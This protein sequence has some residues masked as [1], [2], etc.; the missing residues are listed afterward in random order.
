[1]NCSHSRSILIVEDELIVARDLQRS[2]REMGY[3][4]FAIAAT[5]EEAIAC[6]AERRPDIVLMDIRI[7]GRPDGIETAA[8]L[9][10]LHGL[11][12]IYLTAHADDAMLERAKSTTPHGYMLK[13]IRLP[14]LRSLLEITSYQLDL[15]DA[16]A[17]SVALESENRALIEAGRL[18]DTSRLDAE[19]ALSASDDKFQAVVGGIQDYAIF[20]LDADGRVA[21]WNAGAERM[22][23]YRAEE[24]IGRHFSVLYPTHD[25]ADGKPARE[26][27]I[28]AAAGRLEDEGWRSRKDGSQFIANV[29]IT[30]LRDRSGALQG[31]IKVTRDITERKQAENA[32]KRSLERF[33]IAAAAAPMGFWDFDMATATLT[34]DAGMF[35][36]YGVAQSTAEN[37]LAQWTRSLHPDDRARCTAEWADAIGGT[38]DYDTTFRVIQ[39]DGGIRHLKAAAHVSLNAQTQTGRMTGVAF[40]VTAICE[41]RNRLASLAS[42][43]AGLLSALHQHALVSVADRSGRIIDV[44]DAFCATSG[45]SREELLGQDHR[46]LNSGT[47]GP[48]FWKAA[49]R[50]IS[51][52]TTWRGQ[53]CNR[54][55]NGSLYWVDGVIVPV[56]DEDGHV[57][58]YIFL[59]TD[60]TAAKLTEQKL[61]A[62]EAFL[63]RVGAVA[64]IGGWEFDLATQ[65]VTWSTE[66]YRIHD[67]QPGVMQP[68]VEGVFG[69]YAPEA[70]PVLKQAID[71]AITD[72]TAYDLELR[73]VTA[74]GRAIWVRAVGAAEMQAGKTVRLVGALQ[75]ITARRYIEAQ[76]A[77]SNERFKIAA[78]SGAIGI[79]E[80]DSANNTLLW[81]DQMYRIYGATRSAGFEPYACWADRLH[82]E[83]KQRCHEEIESAVRE[84]TGFNTEFRIVLST[85]EIRHVKACSH[86]TRAA[87]GAGLRVI[88]VNI[89]VTD[90]R[91]TEHRL[92]ETSSLLRTVL[93]SA[94]DVSIIATDPSLTIKVFNAG[95][96]RLLGYASDELV[97]RATPLLIHDPG[98]LRDC[99]AE[100]SAELGRPIEGADVFV[101]PSMHGRSRVWR[102]LRKDGGQVP[103]SLVITPMKTYEGELLGYV[104]VAQDVTHQK[105]YEES[106]R[107]ATQEAERANTAKSLFLANMSH[108]IR[109]PMNAVIGLTYLLGRTE[110]NP[111]QGALL[112]QISGA[113]KSLLSVITDVLDLSKIEA[114]ELVI[115]RVAFDPPR[116]LA[117]L[118]DTMRVHADA[119]GIVLQMDLGADLPLA[120]EGDATRL[121]Q[122]LTNLLSNAIKFTERGAVT[123][124]VR[125][126]TGTAAAVTLCFTVRD[127][128]IGIA[129]EAQARL[130]TPF[131][132]ADESITRR[133]GGTG[134]GLSII[135]NLAKLMGGTVD[136]TS[137]VG[138]GS[139]FRVVLDFARAEPKSLALEQ[140]A[141]LIRAERPLA[142]VRV[143]IVDDYDLNLVV[144]KRI[145]EQEGAQVCSA[146]NG[147]EAC[148]QLQAR[149]HSF[150]VVLMDVQ[151]PIMDGYEATRRIRVELGLV[152]LP[153][154][155][156]TAGA[157]SSERQRA[158]AVGMDGFIIKPFDAPTLIAN[159]LHH[160]RSGRTPGA[161]P[162]EAQ[163]EPPAEAADPWLEIDG[164]DTDDARGRWCDDWDL[165]RSML[166]RCLDEFSDIAVPA[167]ISDS[168]ALA[169]QESRLH[170]LRGGAC[171]LGARTVQVLAADAQAACAAGDAAQA[172]RL[173][174]KLSTHMQVIRSS[175]ARVAAA[176]CRPVELEVQA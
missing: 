129:A 159:V 91:R 29:I 59:R 124:I 4:A 102:Y 49:W 94:S 87:N 15:A 172:A 137:T 9:E 64:G 53:I 149:P 160:A 132:Q 119:K 25:V 37:M 118:Y 117:D 143:L 10:Q 130:F 26:L 104:G 109:T 144:T 24:I 47:H 131:I 23:G 81:D 55:K 127:T 84:E 22:K 95:A 77:V 122:I 27:V 5:A 31:F 51:A 107:R 169:I 126:I 78:E 38:N 150:D 175:A 30:A 141:A 152:N 62:S 13:P 110:L 125:S 165:Y 135:H 171:M 106:L 145:L 3:D 70:R 66:T 148:D 18:S 96:E 41:A 174:E 21:S 101:E 155:A 67:L 140:P 168:A 146:N 173:A 97:G 142:G 60:I 11:A 156:L 170:K 16:R 75:D 105:R 56:L 138:V 116:L 65:V 139:E 83:D 115:S 72:G 86:T 92:F 123:L 50:G 89:D 12:V 28:A 39:P 151:M 61:R 93:D 82:P 46:I 80:F 54:A 73:Q 34:W 6:A 85:G 98:E 63:D 44:N 8:M 111:E 164:I 79:W 153:I 20:K 36:L 57:E 103:V 162:I 108:E 112:A 121:T 68:S 163:T 99:S 52:G 42:E 76:L 17:K 154:V 90:Q 71:A 120:L 48:G 14:E 161:A 100:L 133:Y 1:M 113:S 7:K 74:T 158:S 88:G 58:K 157:L 167:A 19:I 40:D 43:N 114:G 147:K 136:F 2:L 176:G 32:E 45:Y 134:L 33:A 69:F 35:R 128:G 166:A